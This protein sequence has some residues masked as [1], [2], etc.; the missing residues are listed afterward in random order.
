MSCPCFGGGDEEKPQGQAGHGGIPG[1]ASMRA[2][3]DNGGSGGMA[4]M[5]AGVGGFAGLMA[6]AQSAQ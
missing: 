4:D 2:A 5:L 3:G 1:Q 6:M